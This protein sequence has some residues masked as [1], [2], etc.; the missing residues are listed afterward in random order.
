[1]TSRHVITFALSAA[2]VISAALIATLVLSDLSAP[3]PEP[4]LEQA[5]RTL[6]RASPAPAPESADVVQAAAE[7][8]PA[9]PKLEPP[10]AEPQ[11][12]RP[13]QPTI[14]GDSLPSPAVAP[15]YGADE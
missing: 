5:T 3:A 6:F 15:S 10:G 13:A 12:P 9:P 8:T 2:G 1:M 11:P 7:Q 4:T 14:W